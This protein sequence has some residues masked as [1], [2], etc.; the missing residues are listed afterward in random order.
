MTTERHGMGKE[1]GEKL[2]REEDICIPVAD[3]C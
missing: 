2:K 1:V 3:S